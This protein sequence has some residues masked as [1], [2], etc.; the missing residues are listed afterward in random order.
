LPAGRVSNFL[1]LCEVTEQFVLLFMQ[2]QGRLEEADALLERV[3]ESLQK[4]KGADLPILASL[5][6]AL[7]ERSLSLVFF[8]FSLLCFLCSDVLTRYRATI[9]LRRGEMADS[10]PLLLSSVSALRSLSMS[11]NQLLPA[12]LLH[13]SKFLLEVAQRDRH[14]A[15]T[16]NVEGCRGSLAFPLLFLHF[17]AA[18]V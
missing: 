11:P 12:A 13:V 9:K 18:V 15:E 14:I 10:I 5:S 17:N 2:E 6:T 4:V 1:D 8:F 3:V 7:E 16:V